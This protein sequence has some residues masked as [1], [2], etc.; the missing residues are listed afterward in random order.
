[1]PYDPTL[2]GISEACADALI[3]ALTSNLSQL[4]SILS[5]DALTPIA[6]LTSNNVILGDG[7]K[8]PDFD[9]WIAVEPGDDGQGDE[10]SI[11]W[12]LFG[13]TGS[14]P[15]K[16]QYRATITCYVHPSALPDTDS[17]H[18]ESARR[19]LLSRL[20]DWVRRDCFNNGGGLITLGSREYATAPAFDQMKGGMI[21]TIRRGAVM[22]A[23]GAKIWV[24]CVVLAFSGWIA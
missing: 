18:Q 3:S 17:L 19:R 15:Y 8:L 10:M 4:N 20:E 2:P 21:E 12:D 24:P 11:D 6:T 5:H 13:E 22:K 7:L 16:H 23:P 14:H 9:V 1:M